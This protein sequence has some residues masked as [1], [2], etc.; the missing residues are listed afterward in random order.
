[1]RL[2]EGSGRGFDGLS[3]DLLERAKDGMLEGENG[4]NVLGTLELAGD[5][6]PCDNAAWT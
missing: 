5:P 2:V 3:E 1:M 4:G 6:P